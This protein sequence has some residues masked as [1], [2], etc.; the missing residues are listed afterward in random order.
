MIRNMFTTHSIQNGAFILS[1]QNI[2]A[3]NTEDT[4]I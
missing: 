4:I 3:L 2:K 1:G